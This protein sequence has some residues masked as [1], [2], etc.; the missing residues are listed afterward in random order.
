[1]YLLQV[2]SV[3][4]SMAEKMERQ[5]QRKMDKMNKQHADDLRKVIEGCRTGRWW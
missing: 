2:Q 5:F 1:M 3:E 4:T